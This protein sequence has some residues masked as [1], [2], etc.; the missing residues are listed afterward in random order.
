LEDLRGRG[1]FPSW[2]IHHWLISEGS[3]G[4]DF[5]RSR[6]LKKFSATWGWVAG[7]YLETKVLKSGEKGVKEDEEEH[8]Q[9]LAEKTT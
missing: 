5:K 7:W 6:M 2:G 1:F 3:V 9:R 8:T 4:N